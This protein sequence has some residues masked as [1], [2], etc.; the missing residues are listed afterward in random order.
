MSNTH[1]SWTVRTH[2]RIYVRISQN[3][4]PHA[5]V[6]QLTGRAPCEQQWARRFSA[7]FVKTVAVSGHVSF[8]LKVFGDAIED[9][10][11]P[12]HRGDAMSG[13]ADRDE[14]YLK[15]VRDPKILG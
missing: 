5:D 7:L 15:N 11:G 8:R 9:L 4:T 2:H 10:V 13:G 1:A 6:S 14:L 3:Q 12:M